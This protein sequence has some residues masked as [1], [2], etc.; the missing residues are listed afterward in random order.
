MA[1]GAPAGERNQRL[2]SAACDLAGYG[3][4]EVEIAR[5][6]TARALQCGLDS[7]E[8]DRTIKSAFSLP[9]TLAKPPESSPP[10]TA[11]QIKS[12]IEAPAPTAPALSPIIAPPASPVPPAEVQQRTRIANIFDYTF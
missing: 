6:L 5:L 12:P 4:V 1:L 11:W 2:F 8:I 9:R 10:L 3:Y 7:V